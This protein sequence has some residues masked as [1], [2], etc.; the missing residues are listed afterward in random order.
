[1]FG[2]WNRTPATAVDVM[3]HGLLEEKKHRG[4]KSNSD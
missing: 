3:E 1:V 4:A 2:K